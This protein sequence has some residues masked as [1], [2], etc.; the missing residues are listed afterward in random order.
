MKEVERL[1]KE[2][3]GALEPL[4]AGVPVRLGD[5]ATTV[6]QARNAMAHAEADRQRRDEAV[7][8][9]SAAGISYR[10]IAEL[11]GLS[12]QRV[13]QITRAS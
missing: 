7:R 10:D 13:A 1:I 9:L 12:H 8:S 2:R 5:V 3:G 11:L 6:K 4:D